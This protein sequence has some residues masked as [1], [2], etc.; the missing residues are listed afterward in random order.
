MIFLGISLGVC[1]LICFVLWMLW[2]EE[3]KQRLFY[4]TKWREQM[5]TNDRMFYRLL[6]GRCPHCGLPKRRERKP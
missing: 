3:E 2:V 1:M 4:Q 6:S 5:D